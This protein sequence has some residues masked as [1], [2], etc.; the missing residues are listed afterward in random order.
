MR[1]VE[2]FEVAPAGNR[3][4]LV[5]GAAVVVVLAG[6]G[7]PAAADGHES[8]RRPCPGVEIGF[9]RD[10]P[11][12]PPV[13]EG[14]E[15]GESG[16][17]AGKGGEVAGAREGV[18]AARGEHEPPAREEVPPVAPKADADHV[19]AEAPAACR[20][21]LFRRPPR[22][23]L[24]PLGTDR[25]HLTDTPVA[26]APGYFQVETGIFHYG[27]GR[28]G[29]SASFP[30]EIRF[31]DVLA[32]VGVYPGIDFQVGY[33][34]I[35]LTLAAETGVEAG[36][37]LLVR[38]KVNLLGR[39]G[40]PAL[41]IAPVLVV[42]LLDDGVGGGA[43]L[44]FGMVLPGEVDWEVN[45]SAFYLAA[46]GGSHGWV[47]VPTTAL[48]REIV[49]PLLAY[50]EF[51]TEVFEPAAGGRWSGLVAAGLLYRFTEDLQVDLGVHAAVTKNLPPWAVFSGIAVR[52]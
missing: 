16:P 42:P 26:V 23:C 45:F 20:G 34:A 38:S 10:G 32:K 47:F 11:G 50:A 44:L 30:A 36:R 40:G 6:G 8:A 35:T 22:E 4:G 9:E 14:G 2:W 46:G 49:G 17:E 25:P 41:T 7:F 33:S 39:D 12:A 18:A 37:S 19:A 5:A 51:Y 43:T 1:C 52:F 29:G 27:A 21:G 24:G 3:A 31:A 15:S 48:T 13:Q 28:S